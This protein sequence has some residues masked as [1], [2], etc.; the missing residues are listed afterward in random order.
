[1]KNNRCIEL[2]D[3]Y[4]M[5]K[6]NG[7]TYFNHNG[8]GY[9]IKYDDTDLLLCDEDTNQKVARIGW[10]IAHYY[11]SEAAEKTIKEYERIFVFGYNTLEPYRNQGIMTRFVKQVT[12]IILK[13]YE[14]AVLIIEASNTYSEKVAIKN[15]YNHICDYTI[16]EFVYYDDDFCDGGYVERKKPVYIKT[17]ETNNE[18]L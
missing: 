16:N 7:K 3:I 15:G 1:M 4:E 11:Q 12:N 18:K 10:G 14:S 17:K 5:L 6:K 13:E 2:F 8:K 9:I